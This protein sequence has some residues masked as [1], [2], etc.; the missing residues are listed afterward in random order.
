MFKLLRI[1]DLSGNVGETD[2]LLNPE[3]E[4]DVFP[5]MKYLYD[6]EDPVD[7]RRRLRFGC[8]IETELKCKF[9]GN[10][11]TYKQVYAFL[12][13]SSLVNDL[14]IGLGL[15]LWFEE[16]GGT[17]HGYPIFGIESL[18]SADH[19]SRFFNREF[20]FTLRS[21]YI[22]TPHLPEFLNYGNG[23]YGAENYGY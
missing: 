15:Y 8:Y 21:I 6:E 2:I 18:P 4:V 9:V 12:N 7:K 5:E 17:V 10:Y 20:E 19:S 23:N 3:G 22:N 1:N 16:A 11:T 14:D 13:G